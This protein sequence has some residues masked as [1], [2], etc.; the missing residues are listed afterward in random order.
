MT[1]SLAVDKWYGFYVNTRETING[2]IK[3]SNGC[4]QIDTCEMKI[5]DLFTTKSH[6]SQE[7]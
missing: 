6:G 2:K 1:F 4:A 5:L 7:Q 3:T